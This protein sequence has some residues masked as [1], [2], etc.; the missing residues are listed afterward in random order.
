VGD[1]FNRAPVFADKLS[2]L[3]AHSGFPTIRQL[4]P[5]KLSGQ[6]DLTPVIAIAL[7]VDPKQLALSLS[8][9]HEEQN[10]GA[11]R[12]ADNVAALGRLAERCGLHLPR[13][14][15]AG[16]QPWVTGNRV[17][18]FT[19]RRIADDCCAAARV[20]ENATDDG[21]PGFVNGC[22]VAAIAGAQ[23]PRSRLRPPLRTPRRHRLPP[24]P[25]RRQNEPDDV[26]PNGHVPPG[27]FATASCAPCDGTQYD[28]LDVY[29]WGHDPP[30][31]EGFGTGKGSP[32]AG[33]AIIISARRWL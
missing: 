10:P 19:F 32:S 13:I 4:G 33:A 29:P 1:A 8:A 22:H 28:P 20:A 16:R 15:N 18:D 25:E 3:A 24:L 7:R 21:V 6:L 11:K 14:P 26:H 12:R 2:G 27:G 17:T 5:T 9:S 23:L 31:P 30:G